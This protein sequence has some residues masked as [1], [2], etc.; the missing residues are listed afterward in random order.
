MDNVL[1][2]DSQKSG[3]KGTKL[4]RKL[5]VLDAQIILKEDIL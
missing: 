5:N 4:N 2:S 1:L 3:R